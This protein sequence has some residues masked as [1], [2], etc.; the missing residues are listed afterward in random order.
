MTG[1]YLINL[2][3]AKSR[4]VRRSGLYM[5]VTVAFLVI[6]ISISL[7]FNKIQAQGEDS[8]NGSITIVAVI[9]PV[10]YVLLN[11]YDQIQEI[12]SNT[13]Q[14]VTPFVYKNSFNSQPVQLTANVLKQ[15][16]HILLNNKLLNS[17]GV[18]YKYHNNYDSLGLIG[19]AKDLT[20]IV[21]SQIPSLGRVLSI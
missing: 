8:S 15:Y 6:S 17:Y 10:R 14:S 18:I 20:R 9:A 19:Q 3:W 1:K 12:L 2:G 13:Q 21:S 4:P 16:S 7:P 11:N 5:A